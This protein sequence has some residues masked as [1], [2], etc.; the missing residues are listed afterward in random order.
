MQTCKKNLNSLSNSNYNKPLKKQLLEYQV[1]ELDEFALQ[2]GE[3]EQI[4]AEHYKLS[5]SQTILEACQRELQ[6]LYESDEQN[7]CSML[8]HSAQQ[9]AEL[10]NYDESL[11]SVAALL[12]EAAVQV[13]EASREVRNYA[14][15]AD[16]DPARLTEV[17]ARLSGAMDLARKHHIKPQE[18]VEFH[19]GLTQELE[20]I[21]NNSQLVTIAHVWRN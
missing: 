4:E 6:H 3:F 5:N 14:E 1:A 8:Q 9:F 21:S 12:D 19:L 16:L 18:L 13:E 10:A 20:S 2:D 7:A 17:E 15:Q 11:A